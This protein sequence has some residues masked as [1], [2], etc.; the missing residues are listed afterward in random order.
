MHYVMIQSI[1][2]SWQE[3]LV[4]VQST[5]FTNAPPARAVT[6]P[7]CVRLGFGFLLFSFVWLSSCKLANDDNG[8]DDEIDNDGDNNND[9]DDD[10]DDE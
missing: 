8:H 3:G 4:I 5:S 9:D 1:F 7:L 2:S 10:I 6:R